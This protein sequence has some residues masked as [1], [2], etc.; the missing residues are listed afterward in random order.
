MYSK[1]VKHVQQELLNKQVSVGTLQTHTS[2]DGHNVWT[3]AI[4]T[5]LYWNGASNV[6]AYSAYVYGVVRNEHCP[7]D[8]DPSCTKTGLIRLDTLV[9]C[10]CGDLPL[11]PLVNCPFVCFVGV[12]PADSFYQPGARFAWLAD[13]TTALHLPC[14]IVCLCIRIYH[15][16]IVTSLRYRGAEA[17]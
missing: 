1:A 2:R 9:T 7:K 8:L 3:Q 16:H 6:T 13:P 5:C 14:L 10:E 12:Y 4:A 15:V 17:A 11:L